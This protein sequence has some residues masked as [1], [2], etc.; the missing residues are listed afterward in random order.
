[1]GSE[2]VGT[3]TFFSFIPFADAFILHLVGMTQ[4]AR[5]SQRRKADLRF[6]A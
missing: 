2:C 5:N 4:S 6:L 3:S 1:M